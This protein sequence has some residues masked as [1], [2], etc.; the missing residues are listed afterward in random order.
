M[1]PPTNPVRFTLVRPF[2]MIMIDER[3][4]GGPEVPFAEWRDARQTLGSYGP[5]KSLGKRV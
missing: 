5:H 2:F 1:G 3:A 4:H